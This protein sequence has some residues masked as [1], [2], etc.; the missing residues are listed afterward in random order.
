MSGGRLVDLWTRH[1]LARRVTLA[2]GAFLYS[3]VVSVGFVWQE[4]S[5]TTLLTILGLTL[6][7]MIS[8]RGPVLCL[9]L[10][11]ATTGAQLLLDLPLTPANLMLLPAVY[12]VAD[13]RA[14]RVSVPAAAVVLVGAVPA[15]LTWD[16]DFASSVVP[17][18]AASGS[19]IAAWTLGHNSALR[20]AYA[21]SLRRRADQLEREQLHL[22]QL[23]AA[24]ERSR[25][26]RDLHDVISHSMA[27]VLTLSEATLERPDLDDGH[28]EVMRLISTSCRTSLGELRRLLRLLHEDEAGSDHQPSV[29]T[30][31]TLL[32]PLEVRGVSTR[33]DASPRA[34]SLP[35]LVQVALHRITQEAV[36][37]VQKHAGRHV[38]EVVVSLRIHPDRV[39]LTVRDDGAGVCDSQV[40]AGPGFGLRGMAE[41]VALLDGTLEAGPGP[42]G[43]FVVHAVVP[44]DDQPT[45]SQPGSAAPSGRPEPT[46]VARRTP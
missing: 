7:W 3:L 38:R 40:D 45:P 22:A 32:L 29:R 13:Q 27:G 25:I 42:D 1:A 23:A 21:E 33:F 4:G 36:T 35:T 37:N 26:A 31:P 8:G 17:F 10:M 46:L 28:R 34:E 18:L 41:R 16:G 30:I 2:V 9:G 12:A 19:T 14:R 11:T 15:A 44:L 24:H 43:G 20:R 5:L 39:E 6:P